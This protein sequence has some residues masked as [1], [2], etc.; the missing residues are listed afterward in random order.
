M[1]KCCVIKL[2]KKVLFELGGYFQEQLGVVVLM[3]V[4]VIVDGLLMLMG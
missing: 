4:V 3:V 1:I 2:I